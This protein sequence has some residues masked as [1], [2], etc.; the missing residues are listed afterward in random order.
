MAGDRPTLADAIA[1]LKAALD[2]DGLR[3]QTLLEEALA[4]FHAARDPEAEAGGRETKR[5]P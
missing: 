5:R 3:R 1:M 2:A 4:L